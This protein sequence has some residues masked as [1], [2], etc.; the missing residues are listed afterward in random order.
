MVGML[1]L[2]SAMSFGDAVG[3]REF[4]LA[5]RLAHAANAAAIQA[6][7]GVAVAGFDMGDERVMS[8]WGLLMGG[9]IEAPTQGMRDWLTLHSL[10]HEAEYQ[11][12]G[13]GIATNLIDVNFA[14][15]GQFY[16]WMQVHQQ[17]H[18]QVSSA[19]GIV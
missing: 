5:H 4:S 9:K 19:L 12:L 6:Q 11:A 7:F 17:S 8:E 1:S 10:V 2:T 16:D 18:E 13:F 15:R 3:L 14:D